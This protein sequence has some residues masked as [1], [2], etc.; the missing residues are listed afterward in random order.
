[1]DP[2]V[3]IF[4]PMDK[5]VVIETTFPSDLVKLIL[6]VYLTTCLLRLT[7]IW[8]LFSRF[9]IFTRKSSLG[10]THSVHGCGNPEV[11]EEIYTFFV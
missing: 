9:F 8:N 3:F 6:L 11:S 4:Y 1:M 10:L 5:N 2:P 7:N